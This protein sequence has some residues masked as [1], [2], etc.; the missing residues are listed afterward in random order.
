MPFASGRKGFSKVLLSTIAGCLF[1]SSCKSTDT[2]NPKKVFRINYTAGLESID[3]AFAKDLY[4]MWTA[5][6]VYNT[7][8]ETDEQLRLVPSLAKRWD[9]SSDGLTYT[10]YIRND[11][12]FQDNEVFPGGK[13]R[14]NDGAGHCI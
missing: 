4:V 2:N 6:A 11:V 13:G 9:I 1:I 14:K 12:Y 8:L 5:H 3:P 7:L 10:F